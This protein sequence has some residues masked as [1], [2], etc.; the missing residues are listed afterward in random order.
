MNATKRKSKKRSGAS[1]KP[2]PDSFTFYLDRNLG[3]HVITDALR[4]SGIRV[5]VHD[6][7]LA[8][9]SPDED[10]IALVG[11][12]GWI[13]I[14]KDKNIRY[15]YAEIEAIKKNRARVIVIRAKN[16]TGQEIGELLIKFAG[17]IQTFA[18][19]SSSP[20]V[21]GLDRM[22]SITVYPV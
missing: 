3:K 8:I 7:H 2:Q 17:R 10:W 11:Q 14:T 13:A 19:R 18:R 9:D 21:A 22:G 20:F 5:E 1:S 6:D 16:A 15:R 4:L 12:N